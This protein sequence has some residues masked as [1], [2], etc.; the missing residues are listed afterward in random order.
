MLPEVKSKVLPYVAIN[1]QRRTPFEK[2]HMEHASQ[3]YQDTVNHKKGAHYTHLSTGLNDVKGGKAYSFFTYSRPQKKSEDAL[4]KPDRFTAEA[5]T[6]PEEFFEEIE[7]SS[8]S[9]ELN[10]EAIKDDKL[11]SWLMRSI[12]VA[13]KDLQALPKGVTLM[14]DAMHA[15]PILVRLLFP[16][17]CAPAN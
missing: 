6:I 4:F 1:G 17:Y 5:N 2:Y 13:E 14:G 3:D 8:F 7:T 15:T 16:Y 9:D 11:L 10:K 12:E